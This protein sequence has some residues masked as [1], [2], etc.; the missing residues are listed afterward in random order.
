MNLFCL[1]ILVKTTNKLEIV[2]FFFIFP[3]RIFKSSK[4]RRR[5]KEETTGGGGGGSGGGGGGG[6]RGGK[7][8]GNGG[9]GSSGDSSVSED[10]PVPQRQQRRCSET[11]RTLALR[12]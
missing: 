12:E 9:G 4:N 1:T 5:K 11:A 2:E 8:G 10:W 3:N 6:G 7:S